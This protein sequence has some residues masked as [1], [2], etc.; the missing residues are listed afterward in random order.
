MDFHPFTESANFV[1]LLNSQQSVSST[2]VPFLATEGIEDLHFAEASRN[3]ERRTWTPTDD[4]VLISSW[5]NT[6]KDAVIGNEQ[7]SLAFWTRI[8]AYY[9]ASPK[10]AG[11]EKREASHC[12][13]RWQKINDIVCKFCGAYEAATR[14]K[15][16]G[17]NENDVLKLAHE[18][19]F[20]NHNKKFTLEHAWTE[21]R[22]DQ[23]WCALSTAKK[24]GSSKKRMCEDDSEM[25]EHSATADGGTKRPQ[26]VKAAK[27][28]SKERMSKKTVLDG[29]DL[30]NF[31]T[32]WGIKKQDLDMKERL[33][34]MKLLDSLIA[35]PEPLAAYEEGLKKK[36]IDELMSN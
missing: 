26:G 8:A 16:S 12:K 7:R 27:R 23:K 28:C 24:D 14:Q 1:D 21:L 10:V 35:K 34:K 36:L 25:M 9:N 32:M 18:I 33:S 19:F 30:S 6:S 3:K 15:T 2:Q 4:I 13:N 17:Q 22:N 29:N 31:Q 20:T 5:L 11:C